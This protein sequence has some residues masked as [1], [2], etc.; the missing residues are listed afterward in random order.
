MI[1]LRMH[2]EARVRFCHIS[3]SYNGERDSEQIWLSQ[4]DPRTHL[5]ELD[6]V[7]VNEMDIYIIW[8]VKTIENSLDLDNRR[9]EFGKPGAATH[10]FLYIKFSWSKYRHT[11][12]KDA[13]RICDVCFSLVFRQSH[14]SIRASDWF[15]HS[16]VSAVPGSRKIPKRRATHKMCYM[17]IW[18]GP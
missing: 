3:M 16:N 11:V 15:S 17:R 18:H 4:Q 2:T 9:P 6:L 10:S 13:Y 5:G 1:Q 8:C 12:F 14:Y 7:N